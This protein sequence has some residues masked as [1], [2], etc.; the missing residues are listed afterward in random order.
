MF[1]TCRLLLPSCLYNSVAATRLDNVRLNLVS[2][3]DVVEVFQ[4]DAA[5]KSFANFRHVIL[6]SSQR[7]DV[8][9]PTHHAVANQSRPRI[10]TYDP[11][12]HHA[13]GDRAG[14]AERGT[15]RAPSALPRIF[16][17]SIASSMPIIAARISSSTL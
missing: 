4:T 9:F 14:L 1:V 12:D 2:D 11:V 5:L 15:L 17:F 3:F 7:S 13:T 16:S 6:E 8:A 10:A